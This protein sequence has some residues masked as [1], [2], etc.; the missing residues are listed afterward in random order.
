MVSTENG[1]II[2]TGLDLPECVREH[3]FRLYEKL[4]NQLF[5]TQNADIVFAS[6]AWVCKKN[7][8]IR[9]HEKIKSNWFNQEWCKYILLLCLN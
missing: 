5:T 9:L 7:T 3:V 8:C 4:F 6:V 2:F 1:N